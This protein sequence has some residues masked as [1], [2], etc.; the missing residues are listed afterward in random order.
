[1]AT[2]SIQDY[3]SS[4]EATEIYIG[5]QNP[6]DEVATIGD[7]PVITGLVPYTGATTDVDLGVNKLQIGDVSGGNYFEVQETGEVRLYGEATQWEDLRVPVLSTKT[8]GTKDPDFVKVYDNGSGSQGVFAYA[9]DATTEEELYFM[10]QMP[11][12]WKEGSD[13]HAHVHWIPTTIPDAVTNQVSW[14]LEYTWASLGS[15]F[16][17]TTIIYGDDETPAGDLTVDTHYL[18]ELGIISGT[19]QTFSSMIICRVFRDATGTGGTDSYA[20]DAALLE[21]DFHYE[22]D[23]FGTDEE[24]VKY[25]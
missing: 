17:N 5:G 3:L 1:M 7:L 13:I 16:G 11:H 14:G 6:D 24:Y 4:G 2:R 23:S 19:G 12:S 20:Y 9:F 10:V 22:I 8:G 25:D 15:T 18:T 21:I